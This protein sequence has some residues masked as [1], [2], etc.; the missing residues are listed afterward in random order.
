M[1]NFVTIIQQHQLAQK[2]LCH[3][4][5]FTRNTFAEKKPTK[6]FLILLTNTEMYSNVDKRY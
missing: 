1:T 2:S 6:P 3:V 5:S 4:L